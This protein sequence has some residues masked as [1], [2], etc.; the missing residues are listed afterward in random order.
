[1]RWHLAYAL[2]C[3]ADHG[4]WLLVKLLPGTSLLTLIRS[5]PWRRCRAPLPEPWRAFLRIRFGRLLVQRSRRAGPGSSCLSRALLTRVLLDLIGV[6]NQLH[7]GMNRLDGAG[8][9]PHAWL[10]CGSLDL[11]RGVGSEAGCLI[12][13]L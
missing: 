9:V 8:R 12:L 10:S 13:T 5:R 7:I 11:G 2:F 6:P 4:V 3:V 1:M